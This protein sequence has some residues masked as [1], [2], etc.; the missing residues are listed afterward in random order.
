MLQKEKNIFVIQNYALVNSSNGEIL[1]EYLVTWK[2]FV[3]I[4][5]RRSVEVLT[6]FSQ[7]GENNNFKN[8]IWEFYQ[9]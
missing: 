5:P 8:V 9:S 1:I 6:L 2:S 3:K 7:V 4:E